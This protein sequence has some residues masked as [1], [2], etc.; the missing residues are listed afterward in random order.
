MHLLIKFFGIGIILISSWFYGFSK[1]YMANEQIRIM[2][3]TIR[4]METLKGYI[5][6]GNWE[7]NII[8]PKCFSECN[9]IIYEDGKINVNEKILPKEETEILKELFSDLGKNDAETECKR[10]DLYCKQ[11][12]QRCSVAESTVPA[13]SRIWKTGSICCGAA[14]AIMML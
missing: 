7:L 5:Y 8:L 1:S 4:E 6:Y 11:L 9:I 3:K 10:I 12:S 13:K 2:K 14:V